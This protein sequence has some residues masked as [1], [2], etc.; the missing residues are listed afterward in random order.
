MARVGKRKANDMPL[1]KQQQHDGEKSSSSIEAHKHQH[2]QTL[3]PVTLLGGFLGSGKTTLLKHI[4]ESK[5][6]LTKDGHSFK[7][8]VIVNDVAELNIDKALIDQSSF[9]QSEEVIAMQNGCVCCTLKSELIDQLIDMAKSK[10]FDYMII[11]ASGVSEPSEIASLFKEC[12]EDHDHDAEHGNDKSATL[13][14]LARL[15]TCVTV[16][17]AADF[18]HKLDSIRT[19]TTGNETYAKL[20]V[21]QIEYSNVVVINKTDLVSHHQI[22]KIINNVALLNPKAKILTAKH[23]TIDVKQ[24]VNTNLYNAKDFESFLSQVDEAE[25][26]KEC[27]KISIGKGESPC[28][29]KARTINSKLS[30]VMLSSSRLPKTRHES[31]FGINSF[32]YKARRPFHSNRFHDDFITKY[33]MFIIPDEEEESCEEHHDEGESDNENH[34]TT[35]D[36]KDIEENDIGVQEDDD[37]E[38]ELATKEL[39]KRQQE[40]AEVR[41]KLRFKDFGSVLRSKGFAWTTYSHDMMVSLGQAGN[42]AT[43]SIDEPWKIL[44]PKAWTGTDKEKVLFRQDFV[45]PFGDRRQELVFIGQNLNHEAIQKALDDCLLTDEE[46]AMGVDGWKAVVGD[47]FLNAAQED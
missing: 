1:K 25:E 20:M 42:V 9:I 10:Q 36:K 15:D 17:D 27:C 6:D 13:H 37:Q 44:D 5:N 47:M 18:F 29:R 31:R 41:A 30:Q 43:M 35:D 22:D 12:D 26:V 7:C 28:C 14:E 45:A 21:E 32:L 34:V 33:F 8:A 19:T 38:G 16:I 24:V 2:H 3:L 46:F 11:E 4:L 39:I 40:I 23:S